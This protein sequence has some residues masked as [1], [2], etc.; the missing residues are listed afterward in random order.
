M[1]VRAITEGVP[2]SLELEGW[3]TPVGT[4]QGAPMVPFPDT[5]YVS[6]RNYALPQPDVGGYVER[7]EYDGRTVDPGISPS[8]SN[9]IYAHAGHAPFMGQG[10]YDVI[11]TWN[12][13]SAIGN[14]TPN[15]HGAK[16]RQGLLTQLFG[17]NPPEAVS[18]LSYVAALSVTE[19]NGPGGL[20]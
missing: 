12:Q 10:H 13:E 2:Q 8:G 11:P 1:S 20:A 19:N 9:G 14:G 6:G 15:N 5:G 3:T 7:G 17:Y 4:V 18:A 16:L